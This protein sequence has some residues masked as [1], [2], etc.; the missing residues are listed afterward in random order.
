[1]VGLWHRANDP[2]DLYSFWCRGLDGVVQ[3]SRQVLIFENEFD[4]AYLK[5]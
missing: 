5:L 4:E 1:M 2:I 3:P